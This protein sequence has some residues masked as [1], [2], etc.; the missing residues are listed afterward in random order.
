[1]IGL[2]ATMLQKLFRYFK[3]AITIVIALEY[4][5]VSSNWVQRKVKL[6]G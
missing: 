3:R 2:D 4:F 5:F 1:M 6:G